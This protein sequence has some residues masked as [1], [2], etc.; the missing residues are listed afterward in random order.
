MKNEQLKIAI[1]VQDIKEN[2]AH[3]KNLRQALNHGLLLE[4][5]A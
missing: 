2:V 1:N 3:I 5:S 4:K